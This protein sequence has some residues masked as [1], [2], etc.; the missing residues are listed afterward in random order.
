MN[1][2]LTLEYKDIK[3]EVEGVID[4][5][6]KIKIVINANINYKDITLNPNIKLINNVYTFIK[7]NMGVK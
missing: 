2:N 3:G 1:I 5:S 7:N 6:D 4:F